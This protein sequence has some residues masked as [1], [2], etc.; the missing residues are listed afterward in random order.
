MDWGSYEDVLS[1]LRRKFD[2]S[3]VKIIPKIYENPECNE[4]YFYTCLMGG[5]LRTDKIKSKYK[6]IWLAYHV[7]ADLITLSSITAF[8]LTQEKMNVEIIL[9]FSHEIISKFVIHFVYGMITYYF[10]DIEQYVEKTDTYLIKMRTLIEQNDHVIPKDRNCYIF[11]LFASY[12]A[13]MIGVVAKL[14]SSQ[15]N[16][17]NEHFY[18]HSLFQIVQVDSIFVYLLMSFVHIIFAIHTTLSVYSMLKL[19]WIFTGHAKHVYGLL[20]GNLEKFSKRTLVLLEENH[21]NELQ[22]EV[23]SIVLRKRL[24]KTYEHRRENISLNFIDVVAKIGKYQWEFI[25]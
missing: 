10:K 20:R 9:F 15:T 24:A 8:L 13:A 16:S 3:S 14:L 19:K 17:N 6:N 21:Y 11:L 7:S 18:Q 5:I 23:R 12:T 25:K 4:I 2:F 1:Q 22:L